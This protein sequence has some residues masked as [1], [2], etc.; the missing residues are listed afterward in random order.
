MVFCSTHEKVV[1]LQRNSEL[2]NRE[3]KTFATIVG[4]SKLGFGSFNGMSYFQEL[5]SK[6]EYSKDTS[7]PINYDRHFMEDYIEYA[8]NYSKYNV[9]NNIGNANYKKP[10]N[11]TP[12]NLYNIIKKV[13][14]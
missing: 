13:C 8:N 5:I 3:A 12:V 6:G 1:T 9:E 4:N 10:T 2:F 14:K 11:I 7:C